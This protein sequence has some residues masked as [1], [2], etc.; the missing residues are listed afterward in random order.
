[1]IDQFAG[2]MEY[3]T[4]ATLIGDSVETKVFEKSIAG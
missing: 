4:E 1:M 3:S 2:I